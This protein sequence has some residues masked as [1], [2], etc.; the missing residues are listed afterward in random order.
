VAPQPVMPS[1]ATSTPGYPPSQVQPT[2]TQPPPTGA[3][4]PSTTPPESPPNA[5]PSSY[6]PTATQPPPAAGQTPQQQAQQAQAA[7]Q[8]TP[9]A[10]P[11]Q[12]TVATPSQEFRVG[13]GPYTVPISISGVSRASV[14]SLTLTFNPG[15]V[16]V[17]TVQE[18]TFMRQGGV[19]PQFSQRVDPATGRVDISIARSGDA[20]GASGS[21]LLAAIIFDGIAPGSAPFSIS[22][23]ATAPDGSPVPLAFTPAGASVK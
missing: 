5:T 17:R 12:V 22:G 10:T 13:G 3:A 20:T 11:A 18:G 14:I 8:A 23:V 15:T 1:S 4:V 19:T 6:T 16:R 7:Q 2:A 9:P 21:G